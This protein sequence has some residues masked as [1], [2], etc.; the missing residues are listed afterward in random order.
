MGI[1]NSFDLTIF[2]EGG[3]RDFRC[4]KNVE[5]FFDSLRVLSGKVIGT[6]LIVYL[7]ARERR[8]LCF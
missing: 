8:I 6:F 1:S 2:G 3:Q 4:N 5:F 7:D